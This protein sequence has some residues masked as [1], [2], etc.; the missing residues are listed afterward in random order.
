V[1]E[2]YIREAIVRGKLLYRDI[3]YPYGPLTPYLEAAV[4]AFSTHTLDTIYFLGLSIALISAQLVYS[5]SKRFLTPAQSL[6]VAMLYVIQGFQPRIFNY[7]LPYTYAAVLGSLFGLIC[8]Y[9]SVRFLETGRKA[10]LILAGI[11]AGFALLTK[12][13][14]GMACVLLLAFIVFVRQLNLR[15]CAQLLRELGCC[16]PGALMTLI[17]YGWFVWQTSLSFILFHNFMITPK[18]YFMKTLGAQF[19]VN[20][21]LLFTPKSLMAGAG[22]I[23][24]AF[25][26]WYLVASSLRLLIAHRFALFRL[27]LVVPGAAA[28][29]SFLSPHPLAES[30]RSHLPEFVLYLVFPFGAAWLAIGML[31]YAVLKMTRESH[32]ERWMP[33]AALAVFALLVSARLVVRIIPFER[34]IYCDA[35]MFIILIIC[36]VK[37]VEWV[38]ESLLPGQRRL[39]LGSAIALY[40]FVLGM[41]MWPHPESLPNRLSTDLGTIYTREAE[42]SLFPEMIGYLKLK[43]AERK[44]VAV[45]P[46]AP[47][48]YA[49]SG[50]DSPARWFDIPPG[51]LSPEEEQVFIGNLEHAHVDSIIVTNVSTFDYGTPYFG[52][53]YDRIIYKWIVEHYEVTRY[54]GSFVREHDAPFAAVVYTRKQS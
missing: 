9:C 14:F 45:L 48:F 32:F 17:G 47:A 39:V 30:V 3:W 25:I 2:L 1:W 37:L 46:E 16:A 12:Q 40:A 33:Y 10:N 54:F 29:A 41:L 35:P 27:A 51:V 42:A 6:L 52:L 31:A 22:T 13:E 19:L 49:F 18:T 20:Q 4:L 24:A 43:H 15:S 8:L 21:G 36:L 38:T 26:F 53:D 5:L 50:T 34:G 44:S 23:V 7:I 11:A 28:A